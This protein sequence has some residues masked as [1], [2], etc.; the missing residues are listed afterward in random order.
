LKD[1][2]LIFD[3]LRQRHSG[4]RLSI[5]ETRLPDSAIRRVTIYDRVLPMLYMHFHRCSSVEIA[6][7]AY[8]RAAFYHTAFGTHLSVLS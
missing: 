2:S 3:V 5:P 4:I 1:I 6:Y 7:V 8:L